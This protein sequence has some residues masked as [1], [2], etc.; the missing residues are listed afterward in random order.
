MRNLAIAQVYFPGPT[1]WLHRAGFRNGLD[2]IERMTPK[3]GDPSPRR[4][5]TDPLRMRPENAYFVCGAIVFV[6]G[7][8]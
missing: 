1:G 8:G 3:Y 7:F 6:A 4:E 5:E 2:D